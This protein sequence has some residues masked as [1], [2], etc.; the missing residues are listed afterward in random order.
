MNDLNHCQFIGRL[1]KDVELRFSGQNDA[2][3]T[4]SLA[5]GW[6]TKTKEGTEWINVTVFGKLA[7]ICAEYLKKGSQVYVS[8]RMRTE[9]YTTKEGIEKSGTK[10]I[11]DTMQMLGGK[12]EGSKQAQAKNEPEQTDE[13]MLD[14]DIPF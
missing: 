13:P 11:A 6:K 7:E 14:D 1:G 5:C 4:F 2:V 9:K 10:I 8:G 12:S 3:A